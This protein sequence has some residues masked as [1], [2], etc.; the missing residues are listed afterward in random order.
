MLVSFE[1]KS[2]RV[3]GLSFHPKRPWL[4]ASLHSGAIQL[5]DYRLATVIDTYHEHEGP[6]RGIAFHPSQ[7][8]FVSGGD[9]AK[10]KVFHYGL[11]R[12]LFTLTGHAD[13]IR[14]VQFHHELPWIVS[15]S[16]DQT[17]RV[18]NWQNRTCL[19]VLSGHNHYVMCAS[20]HPAEDLVVSASL[21]QT[22]RV[23]DI[24]GLGGGSANAAQAIAAVTAAGL[25][26]SSANANALAPGR[27]QGTGFGTGSAPW[28][29][30]APQSTGGGMG[31]P[32]MSG[33][34]GSSGSTLGSGAYGG[35]TGG[36]SGVIERLG[37]GLDVAVKFTLEGH[38]RGVNWVSFH[39]S[40]P[41]IA[42]G[43]DDRTIKLWRYTESRAWEVD[44]LRG[45]VNNV[46]CVLFHPHLDVL[47]SNSEDKT[48]RV[49]DLS[50][51]SCI[52]IYR[53]EMDRFWILA[54]HPRLSAMAAGHDSGCMIFKL[55]RERP[56]FTMLENGVLVY[57][58]D[59]F[60]RAL[61]LD[62]GRE[63]PVC[64]ARGRQPAND[65]GSSWPGMSGEGTTGLSA[66]GGS[67]G[68]SAPGVL[69]GLST[70]NAVLMPPPRSLQYQPLDRALLL[71][72]DADG[73][74][75]EL[76]QLPQRIEEPRNVSGDSPDLQV[77]PRRVPA[78]SSVLLGQGRWLTLEEDALLLRDLSQGSERRIPLPAT[79]IRFMFPATAGLVL[80]A[81]RDQ[82][83]LWDWQRQ[84]LLATLD[85]PLIRYAV[86]SEDRT[87]LALLAKHTLWIVNRQME[88][89]ALLHETMRIKSAA[90]DESGVLVY[91]TTSHL[92]YCLPNGDAGI[93][94]SLKE[95]LYLTW[96]R[97]PAVA[98]LDRRAQPQ[99][100]A[101]DPTEYT[102]KLL[103]WRKQY[104]RVRQA[105][106]ESRLPGKSMIGY[107]QQKG[108]LDIALWFT[109]ETQTRFVLALSAGYLETALDMA[110]Q[111]DD[112]EAWSS[113]AEKAM[114]YGQVQLAELCF[115]RL[116]NLERLL[117][118]YVLT[119]NWEKLERL[120]DIADAQKDIPAQL[121]IALVLGDPES[122][123]QTLKKAGLDALASLLSATYEPED[124]TAGSYVA[125]VEKLQTPLAPVDATLAQENWPLMPTSES[126]DAHHASEG[127]AAGAFDGA[128]RQAASIAPANDL[129]EASVSQHSS[130]GYLASDWTAAAGRLG[131]AMHTGDYTERSNRVTM[132][133][134]DAHVANEAGFLGFAA[135]AATDA[136]DGWADTLDLE[137]PPDA[138]T[139]PSSSQDRH[140]MAAG[141]A[142]HPSA[143]LD[144][145]AAAAPAASVTTS[146]LS[147][148]LADI[149]VEPGP[150]TQEIWRAQARVPGEW[151]IA[152]EPQRALALL[153]EQICLADP[154]V[155]HPVL[156]ALHAAA[157][158]AVPS[159]SC[160][161][162]SLSRIDQT[163][164][165]A[166]AD[167]TP[168]PAAFVM[169]D[170]LEQQMEHI[171]GL[172]TRGA[173]GEADR[174]LLSLLWVMPF[175][176]VRSAADDAKL[177]SLIS[178]CR[179][180][181]LGMRLMLE[182][183]T[184]RARGLDSDAD[185]ARLMQL[186]ALFTH[187]NLE[188]PHLLL[189]LR[190]AMKL[191]YELQ[192]DALAVRF[193][194]RVLETEPA[195]ELVAAA[196]KVIALAERRRRSEQRSSTSKQEAVSRVLPLDMYDEQRIFAIDAEL[197]V[198][199]HDR[200]AVRSCPYCTATYT[201]ATR[202]VVCQLSSL[203]ASQRTAS[204]LIFWTQ[205]VTSS[206]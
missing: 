198:P 43:A 39:P 100:L 84:K 163:P 140:A 185:R 107:L 156:R 53:R 3:K 30:L 134:A 101:I 137:L 114:E 125:G 142:L 38:T 194:Q 36:I 192:F 64:M 57:V 204:G 174:L 189:A 129:Y 51:R 80:F 15:A 128:A 71:Q 160:A 59:R 27:D 22:I 29:A 67:N 145:A 61:E 111:M 81:S 65:T 25:W 31:A 5:L 4:L 58:R 108:Y 177:R 32:S 48:I 23:W 19:A 9:D 42:S 105:L 50:R 66:L 69:F 99:T 157:W 20:F 55:H 93:I 16:D 6:V 54:V 168:A 28:S 87:Y 124:A 94:C 92:K 13:Y 2:S 8:L 106:A 179:E 150:L 182:Q 97:G 10:I 40:L 154:V 144:A 44:T 91:T 89:L 72:Y 141:D 90:W 113:L 181:R 116:R 77:E 52:A 200:G 34:G 149:P 169:I 167:E 104:D 195:P 186:S 188:P 138:V 123:V 161:S 139:S 79:G 68:I 112:D 191:A 205:G 118:L 133:D 199:I 122:R 17:V 180:Y 201:S 151:V 126:V 135:N 95:P 115:Q 121:Q 33:F 197:L 35:G 175:A 37:G 85:A 183:K 152:G 98:A 56:P 88:R 202:C 178:T 120:Y 131:D 206:T 190:A 60:V 164:C 82:V 24:S 130:T 103:L 173:F 109:E 153:V 102:F 49:W 170:R 96:V 76:Y 146:S 143:A 26:G 172:V 47:V 110:R 166:S 147:H 62:T 78:L 132:G 1:S 73:G 12:C 83:H 45:H 187:C 158:H 11:R 117:F 196:N 46:S 162:L 176:I 119:G 70:G 18:W 165:V 21:D 41:L 203:D 193:A 14:T 7:P 136:A 74:F 75:A 127:V 148:S 155:L 159:P 184:C 171:F 63:W 86:W